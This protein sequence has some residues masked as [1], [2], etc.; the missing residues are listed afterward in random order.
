[1]DVPTGAVRLFPCVALNT[2]DAY[3]IRKEMP[4]EEVCYQRMAR[5]NPD[6]YRT[7]RYKK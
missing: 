4:Y 6:E 3:T 1:M 5:E 7:L 2:R